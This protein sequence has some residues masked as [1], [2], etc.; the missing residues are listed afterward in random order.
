[1]NFPRQSRYHQHADL[2]RTHYSLW[3]VYYQVQEFNH[4]HLGLHYL[5]KPVWARASLN[6]L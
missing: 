1:M 5:T 4:I 2:T 6:H 3:Q